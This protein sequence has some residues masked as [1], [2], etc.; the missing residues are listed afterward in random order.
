MGPGRFGLDPDGMMF[1]HI[2]ASGLFSLLW[3][4]VL[5]AAIWG[6][7][8]LLADRQPTAMIAEPSALEL[9]RRRFVQGEI[10]ITTFAEMLEHLFATETPEQ[11]RQMLRSTRQAASGRSPVAVG[12]QDADERWSMKIIE[13][14]EGVGDAEEEAG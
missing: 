4:V 12:R 13:V 7:T 1:A 8:R 6:A 2:V 3:L 11:T 14:T 10:D 5:G 9:L